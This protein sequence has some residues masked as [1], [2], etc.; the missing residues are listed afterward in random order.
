MKIEE[1]D[2]ELEAKHMR[3]FWKFQKGAH[4][5]ETPYLWKW[6]DLYDGL[7]KAKD[8]V[9]IRET[10]RRSIGLVNPSLG[11]DGTS[12]TIFVNFSVVNPKEVAEAH[13]HTAAAI[14]F[15]VQ[16]RGAY[17]NVEGEQFP[18]EEGDLILTP[19]WTWHDH[20]NGSDKPIIWLDALDVP[21]ISPL[22]V[23]FFELYERD[24]QPASFRRGEYAQRFGFARVPGREKEGR[25]G[26]PFRYPW[27]DTYKALQEIRAED[28]DPCNGSLLRY[29]NPVD[30]GYT[31]PTMSCEIQLLKPGLKTK[32]HRHTS[33]ACYHVFKGS[34]RT[35]VGEGYL[36]WSKGDSFVIPT[37]LWHAHEN[38]GK[39]EAVLFSLSDQPVLEVLE[40]Y[41]EETQ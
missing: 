18:M 3:G 29:I 38:P 39:E 2:K 14:R 30:G 8:S 20:Y 40:W 7:V 17:T 37:W 34:G 6:D 1:L 26:L 15:I 4:A 28:A 12:R 24:V 10:G 41:K 11:R 27:T 9:D 23:G 19:N 22:N 31:L 13:R 33:T 36:E 25:K 16:G 35:R 32:L 5:P 21:L